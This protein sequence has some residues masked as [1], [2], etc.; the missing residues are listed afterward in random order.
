MKAWYVKLEFT[1]QVQMNQNSDL[2]L[3]TGEMSPQLRVF[4]VLPGLKVS[5]VPRPS[6][7]QP[8][9]TPAPWDPTLPGSLGTYKPLTYTKFTIKYGTYEP[10]LLPVKVRL[11]PRHPSPFSPGPYVYPLEYTNDKKQPAQG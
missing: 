11:Q 1:N 2:F 8:P 5:P 10:L 6:G 9:V 3:G 7:S 4:A